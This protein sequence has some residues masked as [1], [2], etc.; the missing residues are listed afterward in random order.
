LKDSLSKKHH[1][2]PQFFLKSFAK[3]EGK[4]YIMNIF[5]K[6][7]LKKF[8]NSID[9]IAYIKNFHTVQIDGENTDVFEK[10]HN[11][12]YER[13]FSAEYKN[14]LK[15]IER[16]RKDVRVLNCLS[17]RR[18]LE[19]YLEGQFTEYEKTFFSCLLA[20]FIVRGKKWREFSEKAYKKIEKHLREFG[21]AY[22][23]NN[24][25]ENIK[26]QLGNFEGI[27]LSQLYETFKGDRVEQ[28]AS[29]FYKH[30]WNIGFNLTNDYFY[31]SDNV[32]ALDSMCDELPEWWGVGYITPGNVIIF[33]ISPQ[34][35]IIMYDPLYMQKKNITIIDKQYVN[36]YEKEVQIINN[37]MILSSIDQVFSI[38]GNWAHLDKCYKKYRISKR[39][40][41]YK[42]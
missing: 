24:I 3:Q 29:Y 9:N 18:C 37:Q 28:L 33:P 4:K 34:I 10:A 20:Y 27:K 40:K 32:H 17:E 31:T 13:R 6:K 23:I 30:T 26:E 1:F 19:I 14:I 41:P 7:D 11:D 39:P 38:D 8:T 25:D 15:K 16:V 22:K 35:C 42:I 36:L 12:I 5:N 21:K 2:I